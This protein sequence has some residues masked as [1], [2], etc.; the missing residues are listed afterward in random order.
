MATVVKGGLAVN[1]SVTI[2][3]NLVVEGT[4]QA[5]QIVASKPTKSDDICTK[6]FVDRKFDELI[7]G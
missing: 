4:I 3:Q 1:K 6:E 5:D 7:K 2:G